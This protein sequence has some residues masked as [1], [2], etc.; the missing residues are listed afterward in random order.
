MPLYPWVKGI[1]LI[2]DPS[3]PFFHF[4][5]HLP[6]SCCFWT[7][8]AGVHPQ[9]L[10]DCLSSSLFWDCYD[11]LCKQAESFSR[12]W[13]AQF[14]TRTQNSAALPETRRLFIQMKMDSAHTYACW[15]P[16][17]VNEN[18]FLSG[19]LF[20]DLFLWRIDWIDSLL[21]INSISLDGDLS[22][23]LLIHRLIQTGRLLINGFPSS[24]MCWDVFHKYFSSV[25][26]SFHHQG[27][28]ST[29]TKLHFI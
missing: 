9:F 4:A 5:W 6:F 20:C 18:S 1:V 13:R 28:S 16:W 8:S 7:C 12:M 10:L 11:F 22:M 3:S 19:F 21:Q 2:A 14:I 23:I 27:V 26:F 29:I 24:C 15:H 25:Y 17:H